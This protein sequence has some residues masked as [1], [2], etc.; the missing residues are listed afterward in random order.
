M[1]QLVNRNHSSNNS[2]LDPSSRIIFQFVQEHFDA[3]NLGVTGL[4]GKKI[5]DKM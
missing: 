3:I 5:Y 2:R 4:E 1:K